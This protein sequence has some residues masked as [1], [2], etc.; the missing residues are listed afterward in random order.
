M[1]D[2]ED[3]CPELANP[4]QTDLDD[5][6]LGDECDDDIDGDDVVAAADNCPDVPN[7]GQEDSDGNGVGDACDDSIGDPLDTDVV[8][9]GCGCD[10]S[11]PTGMLWFLPLL[12]LGLARRRTH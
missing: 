5:D 10:S 3:N 8:A 4:E 9:G 11:A 6:G 12:G 1:L 2:G 7:P